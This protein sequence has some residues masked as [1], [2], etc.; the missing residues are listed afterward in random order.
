MDSFFSPHFIY[1]IY[2]KIPSEHYLNGKPYPGEFQIYHYFDKGRGYFVTMSILMDYSENKENI[3]LEQF[4]REWEE[5]AWERKNECDRRKDTS[6]PPYERQYPRLNREEMREVWGED[7]KR[8]RSDY[9]I[10]RF[11]TTGMYF[12]T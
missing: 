3:H 11:M 1:F 10:H 9:D 2:Q 12:I 6:I 4:I 7:K 8:G 5:V